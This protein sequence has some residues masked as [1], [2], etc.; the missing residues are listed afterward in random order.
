[1]AAEPSLEPSHWLSP[2]KL[3]FL[4]WSDSGD[5]SDI[6]GAPPPA[7][8]LVQL[9]GDADL[10]AEK[11]EPSGGSPLVRGEPIG[12]GRRHGAARA[13][14][15]SGSF[16]GYR[17]RVRPGPAW[18][19]DARTPRGRRRRRRPR[20][21]C[22]TPPAEQGRAQRV[23]AAPVSAVGCPWCFTPGQLESQRVSRQDACHHLSCGVAALSHRV[24]LRYN[25]PSHQPLAARVG[26]PWAGS[27]RP[28]RC[29]PAARGLSLCH[30]HTRDPPA[31]VQNHIRKQKKPNYANL[32]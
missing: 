16:H 18:R 22:C 9:T 10:S 27:L 15:R 29:V 28:P 7:M 21:R 8:P 12:W 5:P 30:V 11:R 6:N 20:G 17:P 32:I 23:P 1:M 4:D 2:T 14:G 25:S 19:R 3:A 24:S 26:A 13:G 31:Y